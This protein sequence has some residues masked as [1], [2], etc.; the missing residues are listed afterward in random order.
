MLITNIHPQKDIHTHRPNAKNVIFRIQ[1]TS[2]RVNL[3]KSPF[4][5][6]DPKTI[7][8]LLTGK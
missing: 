6:F 3:S 1:G 7:L 5:K 8:F 2:K 4:R